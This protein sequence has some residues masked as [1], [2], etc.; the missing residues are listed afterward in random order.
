MT[1]CTAGQVEDGIDVPL[2]PHGCLVA[3]H[4]Q[5]EVRHQLPAE[6]LAEACIQVERL[7]ATARPDI[8]RQPGFSILRF[9]FFMLIRLVRMVHA[10]GIDGTVVQSPTV[11]QLMFLRKEE[12]PGID[13]LSVFG[14]EVEGIITHATVQQLIARC[15]V[16]CELHAC[17]QSDGC[18]IVQTAVVQPRGLS[19]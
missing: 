11:L 1:S 10:R 14:I 8:V 15:V 13:A 4:G 7:F 18:L 3:L 16:P 12:L 5:R 17:L 19:A 6:G 2:V 9:Q